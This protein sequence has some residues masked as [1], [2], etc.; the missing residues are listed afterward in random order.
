MIRLFSVLGLSCFAAI[1]YSS[2]GTNPVF[3]INSSELSNVRGGADYV[4]AVPVPIEDNGTGCRSSCTG[5]GTGL[6]ITCGDSHGDHRCMTHEDFEDLICR[7]TDTDCNGFQNI[8]S[9]SNCETYHTFTSSECT[10][11]YAKSSAPAGLGISCI[12]V[13]SQIL[14]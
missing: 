10:E 5:Y 9:D 11:S 2:A 14:P 8:Y 3:L 4:C 6:W 12:G 1:L 7:L 13:E